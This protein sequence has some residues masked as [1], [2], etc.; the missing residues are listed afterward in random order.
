MG[1]RQ[2]YERSLHRERTGCGAGLGVARGF[3]TELSA[4][5]FEDFRHGFLIAKIICSLGPF[6]ENTV[7]WD[8]S[9]VHRSLGL[10]PSPP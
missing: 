6:P 10:V 8:L 5:A 9:R 3:G 2:C 7:A 4:E 1:F